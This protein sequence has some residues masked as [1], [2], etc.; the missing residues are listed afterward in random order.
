MR[1]VS[2]NLR[3][4]T[5]CF[6]L[7]CFNY[8]KTTLTP[9][10]YSLFYYYFLVFLFLVFFSSNYFFITTGCY[11]HWGYESDWLDAH[12]PIVNTA[13]Q[14]YCHHAR[15]IMNKPYHC[16]FFFKIW[17][18]LFG[19]M[20]DG[21]CFCVKCERAKGKRSRELYKQVVVPNYE[22]LLDYT[23]WFSK[24]VLSGATSQD[25]NRDIKNGNLNAKYSE[26]EGEGSEKKLD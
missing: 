16:G 7:F 20:Y 6:Y 2:E 3:L 23:F 15:A 12:N 8:M 14:H 10:R 11:L 17:D 5:T 24:N 1:M 13:F 25:I 19:S 22:K 26:K 9:F 21:D 4:M 18:Q